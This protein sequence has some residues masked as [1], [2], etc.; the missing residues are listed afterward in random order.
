VLDR[1]VLVGDRLRGGAQVTRVGRNRT[2]SI[3]QRAADLNRL[4]GG[5]V[6][7]ERAVLVYEVA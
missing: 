7:D 6:L 2:V 4:I 1:A 3:I 5:A